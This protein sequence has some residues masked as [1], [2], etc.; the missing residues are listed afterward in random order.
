MRHDHSFVLM[1]VILCLGVVPEVLGAPAVKLLGQKNVANVASGAQ[2]SGNVATQ[3]RKS[4]VQSAK[5]NVKPASINKATTVK[6]PDSKDER[7]SVGKYI[8]TT[9]VTSGVIKPVGTSSSS[10]VSSSDWLSLSDKVQQIETDMESK[11]DRLS[12]GDG[13]ILEDNVISVMGTINELPERVNTLQG[14]MENKVDNSMLSNYYT[15]NEISGVI[16][17]Y[18]LEGNDT[19][20]DAET[21]ERIYVTFIDVFDDDILYQPRVHNKQTN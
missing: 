12:T 14:Q 1:A 11:Q 2:R 17:A 13:L 7:L 21:G 16:N 5:L 9:G 8:H 19:V 20:Y 15:K 6:A 3:N 4:S 10:S 18:V